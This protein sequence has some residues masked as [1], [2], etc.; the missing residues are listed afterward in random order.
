MSKGCY[1]KPD[2]SLFVLAGANKME[3]GANNGTL[4]YMAGAINPDE[5]NV[6]RLYAAFTQMR[7]SSEYQGKS[8]HSKM[9]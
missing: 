1:Y 2:G 4:R 9:Y 7:D 3:G 8:K 6:T 5:S